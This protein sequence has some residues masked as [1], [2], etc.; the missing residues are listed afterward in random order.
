M[1]GKEIEGYRPIWILAQSTAFWPT[2]NMKQLLHIP[3]VFVEVFIAV[4][5]RQDHSNSY[6]GKKNNWDSLRFQSFSPLS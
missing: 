6:E 5:R 1:G 2:K 3:A 4:K